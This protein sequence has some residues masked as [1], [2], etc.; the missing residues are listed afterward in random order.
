MRRPNHTPTR[1]IARDR[2]MAHDRA[3][4]PSLR[5]RSRPMTT[6]GSGSYQYE[7]M[8]TWA[9]LPAGW[10]FGPVSAV[11]TDSQDRVY[12]F[13]RKD[14][15]IIVFDREGNYLS[16]WGSS[17]ITDPHGI[18]IINDVIYLTDREDHVALKFRSEEH[19]SELQSR[20]HLVCRLLLEKKKT[21]PH[22]Q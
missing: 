17:A 8:E 16:S 2:G 19:T 3:R 21:K 1:H 4:S 5:T 13:Q 10:T 15:P 20:L 11:A 6:V 18:A 14:P 22:A 12:A 7:V 9:K